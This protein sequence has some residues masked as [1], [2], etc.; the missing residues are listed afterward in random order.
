MERLSLLD[1]IRHQVFVLEF[2]FA[3]H[4]DHLFMLLSFKARQLVTQG[5][6]GLLESIPAIIGQK[7]SVLKVE[8]AYVIKKWSNSCDI[9]ITY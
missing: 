6:R 4:A 7:Q 8:L 3:P 5:H 2:F 1:S 9:S